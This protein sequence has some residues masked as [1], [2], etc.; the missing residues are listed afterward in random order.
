MSTNFG[1]SLIYVNRRFEMSSVIRVHIFNDSKFLVIPS[2]LFLQL[3][4]DWKWQFSKKTTNVILFKYLHFKCLPIAFGPCISCHRHVKQS[5][6]AK[7][8]KTS[9]K[10]L[11]SE[12]IPSKALLH[13][14]CSQN[15]GNFWTRLSR[16]QCAKQTISIHSYTTSTADGYTATGVVLNTNVWEYCSHMYVLSVLRIRFV[17]KHW[18]RFALLAKPW[19]VWSSQNKW[20]HEIHAKNRFCWHPLNVVGG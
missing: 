11:E 13:H 9:E 19:C 8:C 6:R 15:N 3:P 18:F 17:G 20:Q 4:L 1:K 12:G 5:S 7:I 2:F 14:H 16:S 10:L